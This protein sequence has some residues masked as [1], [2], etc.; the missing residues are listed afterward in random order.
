MGEHQEVITEVALQVLRGNLGEDT[1]VR[2]LEHLDLSDEA[3][4]D[5]IEGI[6]GRE[7]LM[8]DETLVEVARLRERISNANRAIK[9]MCEEVTG[10]MVALDRLLDK[11]GGEDRLD[12][13]FKE[14]G[15][16]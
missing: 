8:S 4:A 9:S 14:Q 2:V 11:H 1:R 5:V 6:E 13:I 10:C 12:A 16:E 15:N 3:A 7:R